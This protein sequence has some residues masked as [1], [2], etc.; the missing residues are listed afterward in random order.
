MTLNGR[1]SRINFL[2]L[3]S[4][5]FKES[6]CCKN[7]TEL[8]IGENGAIQPGSCHAQ[9]SWVLAKPSHI[10]VSR[11]KIGKPLLKKHR[12][13]FDLEDPNI[14]YSRFFVEYQRMQDPALV[15]Y[16]NSHPI[17]KRLEE[18]NFVTK[19]NDAIC[20]IKEFAEYLRYLD[21]VHSFKRL[22]SMRL[23]VC[24]KEFH[25]ISSKSHDLIFLDSIVS[26]PKGY[27][28]I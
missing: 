11:R 2:S 1:F 22:Q 8:Y 27:R 12:Y 6:I 17:R 9:N 16:L 18:L 4:K 28:K 23:K 21:Q 20:S 25:L 15:Q 14:Y 24:S 13:K 10:Q 26:K 19:E 7:H 3:K 5:D